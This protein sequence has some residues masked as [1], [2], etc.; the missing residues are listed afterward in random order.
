MI[1]IMKEKQSYHSHLREAQTKQTRQR[2]L[3]GLV[4]TMVKGVADLS[5]PA[6][7]R[8]AGVSVPTV[9]RYFRTKKALVEALGGYLMEKSGI[10]VSN[11]QL[12]H[13]PEEL[14]ASV[15]ETFVRLE[16]LDDTLKAAAVSE[17]SFEMRREVRPQRLWMIEQ[18]LA[19]VREQFN[20]A[21][22][23]RLRN[24]VLVLTSSAMIRAFKDYLD[25]SGTEAAD[26]V[27]W[28]ILTLTKAASY[29]ERSQ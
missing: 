28:A 2:I 8:E 27:T 15:K 16:G 1:H 13:S 19:P 18:A 26:N 17:L 24:V 11:I 3:E 5:I 12:P 4:K 25:L 21:D 14:A 6:V 10:D 23:I 7:A 29:D 9:Y 20:E 22:W